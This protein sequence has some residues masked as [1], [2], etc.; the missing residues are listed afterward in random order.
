LNIRNISPR[1]EKAAVENSG[2]LKKT[3]YE[4]PPGVAHSTMSARVT[5]D[6][7]EKHK[8]TITPM[9]DLSGIMAA[10]PR[11]LHFLPMLISSP[12]MIDAI[13]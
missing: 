4:A 9:V 11:A 6:P 2:S 1:S 5:N 13:V 12:A 7:S 10:D 8:S 3:E